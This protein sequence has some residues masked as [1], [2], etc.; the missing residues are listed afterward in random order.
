MARVY[1]AVLKYWFN[2]ADYACAVYG[3]LISWTGTVRGTARRPHFS[4]SIIS[5]TVQLW[6]QV[7]WVRSVY[8][9]IRNEVWQIPLGTLCIRCMRFA[10][11]VTRVKNT[12]LLFVYG[13]SGSANAPHFYVIRTLPVLFKGAYD[14]CSVTSRGDQGLVLIISYFEEC[15]YLRGMKWLESG[16]IA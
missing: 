6:I 1:P 13:K 7:F 2:I 11:W 12:R 14:T 10:C 9:N 5:V 3:Y 16:K 15:L 8:F 4:L